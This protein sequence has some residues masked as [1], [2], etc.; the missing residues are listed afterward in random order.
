MFG[1][2]PRLARDL[3]QGTGM[4]T[5]TQPSYLD[6]LKRNAQPGVNAAYDRAW[7]TAPPIQTDNIAD[8]LQSPTFQKAEAAARTR[9]SEEVAGNRPG[10]ALQ[11]RP[12]GTFT[13]EATLDTKDG[14]QT[15]QVAAPEVQAQDLDRVKQQLDVEIARRQAMGDASGVRSL[16]M[17]KN[18]MVGEMDQ[19]IAAAGSPD[20]AKARLLA[21]TVARKIDAFK[22]G[23]SRSSPARTATADAMKDYLMNLTGEERDEWREGRP[24]G[25]QPPAAL[26][27]EWPQRRADALVANP[28]GPE[29]LATGDR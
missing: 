21:Q 9:A 10:V 20:Y 17:M 24:A 5:V 15:I 14:P 22:Q 13:D 12:M 2:G 26:G 6:I 1:S 23:A 19:Q 25:E 7:Q 18:K 29:P 27:Q 3:E 4:P 11:A 28:G 16:T 8:V